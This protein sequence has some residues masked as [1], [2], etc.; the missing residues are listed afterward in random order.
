VSVAK[1]DASA[2]SVSGGAM[3]I[4]A[5]TYACR[6]LAGIVETRA[7]NASGVGGNAG[8]GGSREGSS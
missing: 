7:C 1:K 5:S 8:F 6:V 4:F 2:V 3:G